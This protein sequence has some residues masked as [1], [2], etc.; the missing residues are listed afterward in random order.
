MPPRAVSR[1]Q[2]VTFTGSTLSVPKAK[3][4]PSVGGG[5]MD[6]SAG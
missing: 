5:V 2:R 4:R 3:R 1:S 6:T